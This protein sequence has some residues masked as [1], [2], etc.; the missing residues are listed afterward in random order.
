MKNVCCNLVMLLLYSLVNVVV[1][2]FS[3]MISTAEASGF[4]NVTLVYAA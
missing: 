1:E 3:Q 4:E 2:W